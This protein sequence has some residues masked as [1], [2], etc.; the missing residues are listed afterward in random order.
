MIRGGTQTAGPPVRRAYPWIA[1]VALVFALPIHAQTSDSM[2]DAPAFVQPPAVPTDAE[3]AVRGILAEPGVHVIHFWAP[4]CG[5]SVDEFPA[6]HALLNE[7]RPDATFA[8]VTVWNNG[9]SG[10][11]KMNNNG[12][13]SDVA[14]ILQ[15]DRGPSGIKELRRKEFLGLPMTWIPSTWIFRGDTLAYAINYGEVSEAT[16]RTLIEDAGRS[17]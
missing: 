6:W 15:A 13:P 17:W 14:E 12:I 1:L 10:R 7:N 4:W 9:R 11:E 3:V 16:L 8:F 2:T 5:N